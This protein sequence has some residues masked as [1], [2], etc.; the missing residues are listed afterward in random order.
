LQTALWHLQGCHL[1]AIH[2]SGMM[3]LCWLRDPGRLLL[4]LLQL[5]AR[6][7]PHW[8]QLVEHT[9][10]LRVPMMLQM[11]SRHCWIVFVV[12]ALLTYILLMV[13]LT[14]MY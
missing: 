6:M 5:A 4:L 12:D 1:S 8:L 11:R 14:L 3:V 2:A 13:I 7:S 10:R 9:W